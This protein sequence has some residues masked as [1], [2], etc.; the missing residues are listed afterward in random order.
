[1]SAPQVQEQQRRLEAVVERE[2]RQRRD[3]KPVP[4]YPLV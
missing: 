4:E 3:E 2:R 1:M